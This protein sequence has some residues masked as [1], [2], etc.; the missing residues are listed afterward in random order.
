MSIGTHAM[1]WFVYVIECRDGSLYTG[2]AVDVAARF[3]KHAAGKGGRYTRSHPPLRVLAQWPCTGRSEATRAELA[4]KRLSP[5]AKRALCANSN[6]SFE[7]LRA[8]ISARPDARRKSPDQSR[9]V[10]RK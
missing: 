3:A 6:A 5:T 2:I 1:S 4:I 8:A 10:A 9:K 7:A